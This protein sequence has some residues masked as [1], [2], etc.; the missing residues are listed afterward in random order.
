MMKRDGK[1]IL[2]V[3]LA[4]CAAPLTM[5]PSVGT[6]AAVAHHASSGPLL[7]V[8]NDKPTW[9]PAF[10]TVGQYMQQHYG[11]GIQAQPYADTNTFQAVMRS[12][13]PTQKVPPLFTWWSGYQI[14][15]LAK[16][17][18][19][20][21][22]TP[23][24]KQWEKQYGLNPDVADAFLYKG[25]Y[26]GAPLYSSY[27]V[28]FYNKAVFQQYHLSPPTT[29]AQYLHI[30]DVLKKNG[31]TPMYQSSQPSW[32]GF[33][34]FENFLIN[35]NPALYAKLMAGKVSYT[36]PGVVKVMKLWQSLE[37]KGYFSAPQNLNNPPIP[38]IKGRIGMM[39]IGQWD[40]ATLMQAGM[41][42]GSGFGEFVMPPITPGIGWHVIFETGPI[43]VA[44]NSPQ[45]SEAI[46]AVNTFMKPAVQVQWDKAQG[47]TSAESVVPQTIVV[48]TQISDFIKK[49]H[50]QALNRYWEA[51]PPQ[52]A[53]YG[54][55]E[56]IKEELQPNAYM[57]ILQAIQNVAAQYWKSNQ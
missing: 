40:E 9:A 45:E 49:H 43:V 39:L 36:N 24:V 42:P 10:N 52:I 20:V 51:T 35:T 32:T 6:S 25:K 11:V 38:F 16:T 48:N 15:E 7:A 46:K 41:Q 50:V 56:L 5:L 47:L 13:L 27:W 18:D 8:A 28:V 34:W 55:G 44:R 54:S 17:G 31:V 1:G 53:I 33:I 26:Y 21:D 2:A 30:C 4:I 22:L 37:N 12:A 19:V 23:Y 3:S 14:Q 29:W 57:S